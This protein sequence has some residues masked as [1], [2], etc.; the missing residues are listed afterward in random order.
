MMTNKK[1]SKPSKQ[2]DE[3]L[4]GAFEENFSDFLRFLYPNADNLFDFS[5]NIQFMDKELLAIVPDRDRKKGKRVAD[6]LAKV[7][8]KDGTEKH[9]ML[10]TEIEGGRDAEF[11]KRIYQYNYRIWDRYDI[12]VATIAVY[13]G[14]RKQ[15]KPCEYHREVL[16]TSLRFKY[17]TY[18]IFD[19]GEEE[20]LA[21]DNIFAFIVV[22]CQKALL[23]GKIPDEELGEDRLTIAKTLIAHHYEKDRITNFLIF[24]KNFLYINDADHHALCA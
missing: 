9:I 16:D 21:M 14:S 5:K 15:P 4:K 17:R 13:T 3:L 12:S 8:L 23:E 22:A 18:H 11:A 19:H 20:L 10:N 7:F 6:L 1:R 24:L 2:N